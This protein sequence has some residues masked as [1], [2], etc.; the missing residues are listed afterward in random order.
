MLSF[1]IIQAGSGGER[2]VTLVAT[3]RFLTSVNSFVNNQAP[4]GSELFA[5]QVATVRFLT[6]VRTFVKI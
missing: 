5:T 4:R 1:V 6:S 3:V 2:F